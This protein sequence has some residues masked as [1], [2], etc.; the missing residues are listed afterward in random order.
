MRLKTI[1]F[2]SSPSGHSDVDTHPLGTD[3]Y[4]AATRLGG[5]VVLVYT[6]MLYRMQ[7]SV[8][9]ATFRSGLIVA[10]MVFSQ[11]LEIALML[12]N[13]QMFLQT[14]QIPPPP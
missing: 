5:E 3:E 9:V 4:G 8:T 6:D 2:I 12:I 10:L 11:M 7:Q 13:Q 1:Y 14:T